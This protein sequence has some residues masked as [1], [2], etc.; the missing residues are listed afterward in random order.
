MQSIQRFYDHDYLYGHGSYISDHGN[1]IQKVMLIT[2]RVANLMLAEAIACIDA[3][4]DSDDVAAVEKLK[5]KPESWMI[6]Q[7]KHFVIFRVD[8]ISECCYGIYV[9]DS[10]VYLIRADLNKLNYHNR[11]VAP[12][13]NDRLSM[14]LRGGT[15]ASLPN[16]K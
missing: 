14:M 15:P 10:S 3:G 2:K 8:D 11:V 9:H 1:L 6:P 7:N 5:Y 12:F 16:N 4:I 13:P